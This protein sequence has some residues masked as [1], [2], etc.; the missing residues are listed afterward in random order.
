MRFMPSGDKLVSF[1]NAE[2]TIQ[3]RVWEIKSGAQRQ[4]FSASIHAEQDWHRMPWAIEVYSDVAI[5]QGRIRH[6]P[7]QDYRLVEAGWSL[8]SG[9]QLYKTSWPQKVSIVRRSISDDGKYLAVVLSNSNY[10]PQEP[11]GE[12]PK[13]FAELR[14]YRI[15]GFK[16]LFKRELERESFKTIFRKTED[17]KREMETLLTRL[18]DGKLNPSAIPS[19]NRAVFLNDGTLAVSE[20]YKLSIW[21]PI[22]GEELCRMVG[23]RPIQELI[24][25]PAR[26]LLAS[27]DF[28]GNI[29]LWHIPQRKVI[30]VLPPPESKP[31]GESAFLLTSFSEDAKRLCLEG[32]ESAAFWEIS[33]SFTPIWLGLLKDKWVQG[34]QFS[35]NGRYAIGAEIGALSIWDLDH[36]LEGRKLVLDDPTIERPDLKPGQ[37]LLQLHSFSLARNSPWILRQQKG[38]PVEVIREPD[39]LEELIGKRE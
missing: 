28:A 6:D 23:S 16:L 31:V 39:N 10:A 36:L 35:R 13:P 21:D 38:K 20:G 25:A 17:S 1:N 22:E 12:F 30:A 5:L 8:L 7:K 2:A 26:G 18:A 37:P 15:Q 11:W 29:Q 9:N 27:R 4:A 32:R 19:H 14:V 3:I 33:E 24:P 34:V